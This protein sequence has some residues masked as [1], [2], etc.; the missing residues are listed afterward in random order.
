M[1]DHHIA[2]PCDVQLYRIQDSDGRGPWRPGFSARWIDH[3]KDDSTCPPMKV[4]FP[5]WRAAV[6]SAKRRGLVHF[7]CCA[8]GTSGIRMWFND[9]EIRRLRAFGY[10]MVDAS[11][12]TTICRGR[13]QVIAASRFPLAYLP[14]IDW[15]VSV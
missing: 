7:G 2:A 10:H 12:L 1:V 5:D 14:R 8:I 15:S 4:E 6:R 9:A 13:S 3:E 11:A